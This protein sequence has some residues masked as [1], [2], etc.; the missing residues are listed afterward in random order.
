VLD[1]TDF[2]TVFRS[3]DTIGVLDSDLSVGLIEISRGGCLFESP[4]AI[5]VG[6]IGRLNVEIDGALYSED[7]RVTRCLQ[8]RGAGERHQVGVAFLALRRPGRQSLRLYA[9]SLGKQ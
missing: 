8:V 7:V 3:P 1:V 6:T 4:S 5:P 9:A 2:L